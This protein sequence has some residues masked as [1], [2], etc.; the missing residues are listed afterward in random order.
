MGHTSCLRKMRYSICGTYTSANIS[1]AQRTFDGA[2]M[3]T[4]LSQLTFS[5]AV[6]KIFEP[7][8]FW[9]GLLNC[10]LAIGLI[11][12]SILRHRM[13]MKYEER[14]HE[15]IETRRKLNVH[16]IEDNGIRSDTMPAE[17]Y[18]YLPNFRT[19][20]DIV[21]FIAIY[22]VAVETV[23]IYFLSEL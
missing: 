21:L 9:I 18:K 3:R 1:A 8:F 22:I 7:K 4:A 6:I 19:A 12:T 23:I 15:I 16:R 5:L 20:G 11:V 2:Y 13:T 17:S 14:V 10:V